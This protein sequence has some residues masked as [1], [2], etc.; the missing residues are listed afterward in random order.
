MAGNFWRIRRRV[1]ALSKA[2]FVGLLCLPAG[3][4]PGLPDHTTDSEAW[5]SYEERLEATEAEFA[6]YTLLDQNLTPTIWQQT[7]LGLAI[8]VPK[9]FEPVPDA[10]NRNPDQPLSRKILGEPLPGLLGTWKAV[11][12]G[13]NANPSQT[14][15]LFLMS[16]HHLWPHAE[17]SALAF[18]QSL[19]EDSLAE[20]PGLSQLPIECDWLSENLTKY[21][22][23]YTT[24]SFPAKLPEPQSRVDVTVFLF[25]EG[26]NDR[27]DQIKVALMFVVPQA[28][29]FSGSAADV[30]P[31]ALAAQTLRITPRSMD[32]P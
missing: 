29:Q 30:D 16:N 22:L 5:G 6:Y 24:A 10:N 9:P 11:L 13:K 25:Q 31:K 28:A 23:P 4:S 32:K 17:T 14:A 15:Y 2:V 20:L 21:G 12:P 8:R 19:V 26:A 1:T 27:R 3:C 18:H 7:E